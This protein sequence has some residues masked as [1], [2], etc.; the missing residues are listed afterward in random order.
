MWGKKEG[1][2][3]RPPRERRKGWLRRPLWKEL[4]LGLGVFSFLYFSNVSKFS[5]S[6]CVCWR[7]VFIGQIL[8]GF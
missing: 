7:P 4:L 1:W 3:R 8:L 2:G 6:F 5:P